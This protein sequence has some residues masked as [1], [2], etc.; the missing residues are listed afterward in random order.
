MG[1]CPSCG[2]GPLVIEKVKVFAAQPLGGFSLAGFQ[3]KFSATEEERTRLRCSSCNWAVF[4]T[5]EDPVLA[6]DGVTFIGGY[7]A[8]EVVAARR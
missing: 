1:T 3:V 2:G 7:F 4:G 5:I 6:E 8:V